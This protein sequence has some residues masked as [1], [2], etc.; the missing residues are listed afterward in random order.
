VT[1]GAQ[2]DVDME[3]DGN[4]VFDPGHEVTDR[5]EPSPE[6]RRNAP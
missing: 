2:L 5:F 6:T 3:V 4:D 1:I